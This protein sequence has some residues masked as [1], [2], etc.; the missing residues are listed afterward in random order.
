MP[1]AIYLHLQ[2]EAKQSQTA[3]KH[4]EHNDYLVGDCLTEADLRLIPT[5][6]R[7]DLVYY[8]HFK[9]NIR[10]LIDYNH[11]SRYTANLYAIEAISKN[12]NT[13]HIKR[14]YYYSHQTINPYRIVPAGPDSIF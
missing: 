4:L 14:H 6:L 8:V 12:H 7:F 13:A 2:H 5:L 3:Q 10:R 9:T 1:E 11:L